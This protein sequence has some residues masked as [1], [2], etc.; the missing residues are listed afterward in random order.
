MTFEMH[1]RR[2]EQFKINFMTSQVHSEVGFY[3][4]IKCLNNL[5]R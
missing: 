2:V 5:S 1:L 4:R 3:S